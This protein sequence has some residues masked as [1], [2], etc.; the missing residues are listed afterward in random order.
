ML[1][2]LFI[3]SKYHKVY[4]TLVKFNTK[5]MLRLKA[6]LFWKADWQAVD[7]PKKRTDQFDLFAVKNKK[8]NETNSSVRFYGEVRRP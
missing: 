7:S 6:K 3:T 1:K 8:A 4:W 2:S 5:T